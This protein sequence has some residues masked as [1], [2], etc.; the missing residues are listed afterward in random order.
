V[1][2]GNVFPSWAKA[3]AGEETRVTATHQ[4]ETNLRM[5]ELD[6]ALKEAVRR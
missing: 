4:E 6:P 3:T 2:S 1:H 5:L